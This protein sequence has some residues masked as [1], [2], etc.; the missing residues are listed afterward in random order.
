[1]SLTLKNEFR[2][3]CEECFYFDCFNINHKLN[4]FYKIDY[5]I[6]QLLTHY[7]N[8]PYKITV[9]IINYSKTYNRCSQCPISLCKNHYNRAI[10]NGNYYGMYVPMCDKCCWDHI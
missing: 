5:E 7:F 2:E 9:K 6:S 8:I 10:D 3:K 4:K 1:M